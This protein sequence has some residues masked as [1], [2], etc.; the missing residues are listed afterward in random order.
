MKEFLICVGVGL[1]CIV[2]MTSIVTGLI[3][4]LLAMDNYPVTAGIGSLIV[5]AWF[6]G[7]IWRGQKSK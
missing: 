4:L 5:F 6:I 1:L 3:C 2:G 7:T